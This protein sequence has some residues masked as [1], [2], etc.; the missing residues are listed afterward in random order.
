MEYNKKRRAK[1]F[2]GTLVLLIF[3]TLVVF[4]LDVNQHSGMVC[5]SC[6]SMKPQ[7]LTWQVSSHSQAGCID[8]HAQSGLKGSVQLAMDLVRFTIKEVSGDFEEPIRLLP[9]LSEE[10]CLKCH[11]TS[12][13]VT[14]ATD[15]IIPHDIH[16][17]RSIDCATCHSAVVHGGIARRG[18]TVERT[19]W[20]ESMAVSALAW[21]NTVKPMEECMGC[22]QLLA[23]TNDCNACHAKLELPTYH[24]QTSFISS[25]GEAAA[26]DL[27]GCNT[28]HGFSG[29]K[30]LQV[31]EETTVR[32]YSRENNFCSDCHSMTPNSH[33]AKWQR[34][35]G[36]GAKKSGED[37][38]LICHDTGKTDTV[39][40]LALIG[41][42]CGNCHPSPHRDGFKSRHYPPLG[43]SSGPT[44]SCF[45]C[46]PANRCI[47]CHGE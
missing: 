3:C 34:Q 25:H 29:N 32:S 1:F 5:G 17:E 15:I 12:R 45:T 16:A 9:N 43:N 46:H 22:H 18:E 2:W 23:V 41:P 13:Y 11:L 38:C 4:S 33:T 36:G 24:Q 8:C 35:H 7:Q 6:H 30:M 26:A 27:Q 19:G 14:S 44:Q 37:G 42:S 31:S 40:N 20:N 39:G 10:R 28:C 21:E 47:S